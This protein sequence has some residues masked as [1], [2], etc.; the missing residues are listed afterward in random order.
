MKKLFAFI[1]VFLFSFQAQAQQ[2][3][4]PEGRIFIALL[5]TP[6]IT[7]IPGTVTAV[8]TKNFEDQYGQVLIPMGARLTGNYICHIGKTLTRINITWVQL[9][10]LNNGTQP[11]NGVNNVEASLF[12][13]FDIPNSG[14]PSMM[15]VAGTMVGVVV[16]GRL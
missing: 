14:Q 11:I 9:A 13:S 4:V 15:V 7:D 5:E 2:V 16:R 3:S 12:S 8:V 10:T 1:A 6:I